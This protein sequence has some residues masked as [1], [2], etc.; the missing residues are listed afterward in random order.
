MAKNNKQKSPKSIPRTQQDVDR[1]FQ[2]GHE[3]GFQEGIKGGLVIMIYTLKDKF[4]AEDM[5]LKEF[6]DAYNYVCD[7]LARDYIK[8]SDLQVVLKEEYGTT[9]RITDD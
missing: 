3:Q 2:K 6:S 1:A 7:S 5:Q 4:G 8:T 9:L